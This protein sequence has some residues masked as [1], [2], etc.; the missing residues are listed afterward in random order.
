MGSFLGIVI[1]I[2]TGQ[3]PV[4]Q[5]SGKKFKNFGLRVFS[6]LLDAE[7]RLGISCFVKKWYEGKGLTDLKKS[8]LRQ[9]FKRYWMFHTHPHF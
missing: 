2:F 5:T 4:Y 3:F 8:Y 1:L 6:W 7:I 9:V